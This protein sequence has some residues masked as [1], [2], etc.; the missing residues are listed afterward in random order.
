M[1]RTIAQ[2]ALVFTSALLIMALVG[3]GGS[4][5]KAATV[6]PTEPTPPVEPTPE[7]VTLTLPDGH[8][9]DGGTLSAGSDSPSLAYS[10][11]RTTVL[12]CASGGEACVVAVDGN[13]ASVTGGTASL[14]Y[15][16]NQLIWQA[17][18][19]PGDTSSEGAHAR[20][21]V[22]RMVDSAST[23]SLAA[24]TA[25][26][27]ATGGMNT[28]ATVAQ[29]PT[30]SM[31][32]TSGSSPTFELTLPTA[33]FTG[34]TGVEGDDGKLE[35]NDGSASPPSIAGWKGGPLTK[36]FLGKHMHAVMY[37]DAAAPT[38]DMSP[39]RP[40]LTIARGIDLSSNTDLAGAWGSD[41][42]TADV[43]FEIMSSI[44][45]GVKVTIPL[46]TV[47]SLRDGTPQNTPITGLTLEYQEGGEDRERDEVTMTCVSAVCRVAGG[48]LV[49]EWNLVA[50]KD[51]AVEGD[52][53]LRYRLLGAWLVLPSDAAVAATDVIGYNLGS[54]S[55]DNQTN[56]RNQGALEAQ[57]GSSGSL[58]FTGP[59]TGLYMTG[60]YRGSGSGRRVDSAEVG[61][62]T[63]AAELTATTDS[64][65]DLE[66]I[67]GTVT[68]FR[69]ANSRDL[70]WRMSL[71]DTG[72]GADDNAESFDGT[73]R[74]ET[75]NAQAVTGNWV[76]QFYYRDTDEGANTKFAGGTFNASSGVDDDK[77]V[78]VV[79]AFAATLDTD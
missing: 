45:E 6:T 41:A 15:P 61:S 24:P 29:T 63:A 38:G 22:G 74:L 73:T 52:P 75:S 55:Y 17:N 32:W 5:K 77:A 10:T 43:E 37:T 51:D 30:P 39:E 58:K 79:G 68:N 40:A 12:R 59:A 76:T 4:S 18:N 21:F 60:E 25:T 1:R 42:P 36:S 16:T 64:G 33:V 50:A 34:L 14:A 9:W 26:T 72:P 11:G 46:A 2:S 3:C 49:G 66:G 8:D 27:G 19:G 53:D 57:A 44:G 71:E 23:T 70:G 78:H 35:G 65:G 69:D 48:Q 47:T 20:G 67:T 31:T 62:F 7:P 54:F 13:T 28:Q 56:R